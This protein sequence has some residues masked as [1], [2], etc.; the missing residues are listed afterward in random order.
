MAVIQPLGH[1]VLHLFLLLLW[2]K[3]L[4]SFVQSRRAKSGLPIFQFL[5]AMLSH[6][7]KAVASQFANHS[8]YGGKGMCVCVCVRQGQD[9]SLPLCVSCGNPCR[10]LTKELFKL[11]VD[12]KERQT[13]PCA[14]AC[15]LCDW[16]YLCVSCEAWASLSRSVCVFSVCTCAS[17][18][19][20]K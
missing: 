15:A 4:W 3:K 14:T 12:T 1:L 7:Y 13:H 18:R 16:L 5:P 8:T 9:S 10:E 19:E 17:K 6:S 11:P 2:R 20:W